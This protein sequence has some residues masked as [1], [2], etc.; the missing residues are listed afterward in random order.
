MFP[1]ADATP[2]DT[3]KFKNLDGLI[4]AIYNPLRTSFIMNGKNK[5]I[6]AEGGLYMLVSQGIKASELFFAKAYS[7]DTYNEV[8]SFVTSLQENIV[9]TGMP[10]S[11]K[12]AIAEALATKTGKKYFDT[13]IIIKEK[14]G[15]EI[16]DIFEKYGEKHF[17]DLE[18]DTIKE[19]SSLTG[20]IISTGG[21][22]ILRP[23]NINMLKSNGHIYYI[24]RD[25]DNIIPTDDR[26]LSNSRETLEKRF[27]ERHDIYLSTADSI[28]DNNRTLEEAVDSIVNQLNI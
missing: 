27:E 9:L 22:S 4:D 5:G 23:E 25:I 14:T 18:S 28:I 19:L 20:I 11:G 8:F 15:M 24:D 1:K 26:P 10:G 3:N 12:S 7:D 13:D 6:T 17:R 16:S 21:G 2:I